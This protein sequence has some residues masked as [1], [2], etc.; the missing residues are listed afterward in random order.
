MK[1]KWEN[2]STLKYIDIWDWGIRISKKKERAAE[3]FPQSKE[4][5]KKVQIIDK[6][7][8][9]EGWVPTTIRKRTRT[10]FLGI[11]DF[12]P[13][14][15]MK[16]DMTI[17]EESSKKL[18]KDGKI[19]KEWSFMKYEIEVERID[20]S[21][22]TEKFLTMVEVLLRWMLG[23]FSYQYE[24]RIPLSISEMKKSRK[25]FRTEARQWNNN[26]LMSL[27]ERRTAVY[28]H[29]KLFRKYGVQPLTYRLDNYYWNKPEN[30]FIRDLNDPG[31]DW[32]Y[33][34]KYD[35]VRAFLLIHEYGIYMYNLPCGVTYMGPGISGMTGTLIDGEFI[36][37]PNEDYYIREENGQMVN[38]PE[39]SSVVEFWAFDL[40]FFKDQ[41]LRKLPLNSR[42]ELL[43]EKVIPYLKRGQT[44][45]FHYLNMKEYFNE[46]DLGDEGMTIARI[47]LLKKYGI[48]G[49]KGMR[50]YNT[51]SG[52]V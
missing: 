27:K 11:S 23:D 51:G 42:L 5:K 14:S 1:D 7:S 13:F 41:D 9:L 24:E 19:E 31:M 36:N 44:G 47:D 16:I 35:G 33:T 17:V 38:S 50:M 43:R 49:S 25:Q 48:Y 10:T 18:G 4:S 37:K 40:L 3:E 26:H 15:Q 21:L 12:N 45:Q 2:K 28:L 34:V 20:P 32:S 46:D 30:V 29:N 8:N 22:P 6:I 52:V 39:T